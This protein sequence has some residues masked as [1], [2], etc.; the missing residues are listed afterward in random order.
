MSLKFGGLPITGTGRQLHGRPVPV[1]G[2]I[3]SPLSRAVC[4]CPVL[5]MSAAP[6]SARRGWR[7][8]PA[9]AALLA[10]ALLALAGTFGLSSSY[11]QIVRAVRVAAAAAK[12]AQA[13]HASTLAGQAGAP[14]HSA[15]QAATHAP[16]MADG[17][18]AGA[19]EDLQPLAA[20]AA[21]PPPPAAAVRGAADV[22]QAAAASQAQEV[23][24]AAPAPKSPAAE[25]RNAVAGFK[26]LV[27]GPQRGELEA[28]WRRR[29]QDL[30]ER[31]IAVAAGA[32]LA[33]FTVMA[34]CMHAWR[35]C[36]LPGLPNLS[37]STRCASL[38][39]NRTRC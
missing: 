2:R 1:G 12:P 5:G 4:L 29:L 38:W 39:H 11:V 37:N 17:G 13:A 25:L 21:R 16:Q 24:Q 23:R 32:V 36:L 18:A 6:A 3:S 20:A 28:F 22:R 30:P 33:R 19:G 14:A 26:F 31:G 8:A 15:R 7:G 10:A 34:H 35:A 27:E 9:A